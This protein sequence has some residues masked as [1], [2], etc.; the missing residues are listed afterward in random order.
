MSDFLKNHPASGEQEVWVRAPLSRFLTQNVMVID[1][2]PDQTYPT[3]GVLNR[4]RGLLYRDPVAGSSTAYKKLNR[5]CPGVLVY[6]RLKAFEGAITVTPDNL[7][8]SF[9]SQ[10]LADSASRSIRLNEFNE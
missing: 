8:E 1:V 4:G 7:P 2:D 6:S 10:E 3:V 9:A 5:I